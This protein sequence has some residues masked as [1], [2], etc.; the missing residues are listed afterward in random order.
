MK[1]N[2]QGKR[3]VTIK[4]HNLRGASGRVSAA[5]YVQKKRGGGEGLNWGHHDK[6]HHQQHRTA[7]IGFLICLIVF[8]FV[9]FLSDSQGMISRTTGQGDL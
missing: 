7:A 4:K 2:A 5:S 8:C 3:K 1:N 6:I 9:R